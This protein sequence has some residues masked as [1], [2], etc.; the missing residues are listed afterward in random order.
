MV[1]RR[2]FKAIEPFGAL[3]RSVFEAL[4]DVQKDFP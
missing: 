1:A 2:F 3:A 4:F